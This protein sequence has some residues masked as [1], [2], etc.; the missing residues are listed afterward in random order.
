[1]R[2]LA[3]ADGDLPAQ[4]RAWGHAAG[5]AVP[6]YAQAACRVLTWMDGHGG[7]PAVRQLIRRMAAGERFATLYQASE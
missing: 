2:C 7:P 5:D 1:M 4:W 6:I 3:A